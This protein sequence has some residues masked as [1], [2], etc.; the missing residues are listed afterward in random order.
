MPSLYADEGYDWEKYYYSY[1]NTYFERD[2][3]EL[4]QVGGTMEFYIS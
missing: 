1:V 4:A 2:V 3:R